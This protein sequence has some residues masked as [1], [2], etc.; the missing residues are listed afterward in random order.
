VLLQALA[1]SLHPLGGAKLSGEVFYDGVNIHSKKFI[2]AKIS[3][4]IEQG[5][6]HIAVLTVEETLKFAWKYTTGGHHSYARAKDETSS[7]KLN[8]DD[9]RLGLIHNILLT[10]GLTGCK[11]TCVGDGMIR[12]ISGGQ[13]RRVT[14]SE[15]V[16]CPRPLKLMD[17]VS[18]GLDSI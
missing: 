3:D 9:A 4:Y 17:S 10:L 13:K 14:V 18:N 7:A 15:M 2:P 1:G 6:T 8:E 5:D 11:D 12:R 16:S